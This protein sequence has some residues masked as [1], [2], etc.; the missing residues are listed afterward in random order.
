MEKGRMRVQYLVI[1]K[2]WNKNVDNF[3]GLGRNVKTYA[4]S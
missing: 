4:Y 2:K 1:K 3:L